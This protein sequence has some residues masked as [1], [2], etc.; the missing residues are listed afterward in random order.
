MDPEEAGAERVRP[1]GLNARKIEIDRTIESKDMES[2]YSRHGHA[3]TGR[4]RQWAEM[5]GSE[6]VTGRV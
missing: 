2:S 4:R 1:G 6:A 5:L 3:M